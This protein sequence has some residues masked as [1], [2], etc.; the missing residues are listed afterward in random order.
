MLIRSTLVVGT[1]MLA[2]TLYVVGSGPTLRALGELCGGLSFVVVGSVWA[3]TVAAAAWRRTSPPPPRGGR[4]TVLRSPLLGQAVVI[5]LVGLLGATQPRVAA[6]PWLLGVVG[7]LALLALGIRA[8]ARTSAAALLHPWI[9]LATTPV[10]L[11]S[12]FWLWW[13]RTHAWAP[14]W[15]EL[16]FTAALTVAL[17]LGAWLVA[18]RAPER[19]A[20]GAPRDV[21]PV[22]AGA[23]ILPLLV[24]AACVAA[25]RW[26]PVAPAW[27]RLLA[28]H[29]QAALL[30]VAGLLGLL[31]AAI[32]VAGGLEAL[33]GRRPHPWAGRIATGALLGLSL[34][35]PSIARVARTL[36]TPGLPPAELAGFTA[37]F[38]LAPLLLLLCAAFV[39]S[40]LA[41]LGAGR[42]GLGRAGG[43]VLA[44]L[45]PVA[46]VGGAWWGGPA[47][48]T[49]GA[50]VAV[51][52]AWLVQVL[53]AAPRAFPDGPS[54]VAR[55]SR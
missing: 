15:G 50:L 24:P 23:A 12:V 41:A 16:H 55:P 6:L 17:A 18:R 38:V 26:G 4:D 11:Y 14:R 13:S 40:R 30:F 9:V 25:V 35:G 34:G 19:A 45:G 27:E 3:G 48:V 29:G 20:A 7:A 32:L 37:L 52:V 44:L 43:L 21:D 28:P 47:G 1:A 5:V 8:L 22:R 36:L 49:T 51:G 46:L 39:R 31:P 10:L 42:D 33:L 53:Q 54:V 2:W